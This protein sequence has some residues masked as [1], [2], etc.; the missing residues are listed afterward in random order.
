MVA[1]GYD[2]ITMMNN[3]IEIINE[4]ALFKKPLVINL[5]R[6][7]NYAALGGGTRSSP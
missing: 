6:N 4:E 7:L 1:T 3:L 5:K 2:N